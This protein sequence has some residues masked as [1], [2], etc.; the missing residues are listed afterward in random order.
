MKTKISIN[1]DEWYFC[2]AYLYHTSINTFCNIVHALYKHLDMKT[3]V[4][5]ED[6]R[7]EQNKSSSVDIHSHGPTAALN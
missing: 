6:V 5:Y 3:I 2:F 1:I 4:W 7:D